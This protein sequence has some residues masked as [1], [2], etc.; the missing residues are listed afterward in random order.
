MG[1]VLLYTN[2]PNVTLQSI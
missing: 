2:S 1:L